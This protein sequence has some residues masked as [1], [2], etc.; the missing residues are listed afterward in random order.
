MRR[1]LDGAQ[2]HDV[3]AGE[4]RVVLSHYIERDAEPLAQGRV[5]EVDAQRLRQHHHLARD[6]DAVARLDDRH[7]S[8]GAGRGRDH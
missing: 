8:R 5:G 4:P 7:V 2:R 1:E 3:E 6:R